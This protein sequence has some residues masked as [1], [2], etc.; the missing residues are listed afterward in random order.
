M[1]SSRTVKD[2]RDEEFDTIIDVRSPD[3]FADDH[4]PGAINLPVLSNEERVEVGTLY[5]Q[6]SP[7]RARVVGAALV[8]RN[9]GVHIADSLAE[10][11]GGWKPLIYCWRGGQRSQSMTE[12]LSQIGW[13]VCRLEGGYKT[14]RN[15]VMSELKSQL[16]SFSP[17]IVQGATGTGK[18]RLLQA[19]REAGEQVLD[20]EGLAEHRGSVLGGIPGRNQPSQRL[21]ESRIWSALK[22]LD[23]ERPVLV[24]AESSKVGEVHVPTELWKKMK[25]A[26]RVEITLS[27]EERVAL[28]L[29]EYA[30]WTQTPD[31]LIAKLK[32]LRYRLG[33]ELVQSW[34]D[35]IEAKDWSVFVKALLEAHYDRAY[36]TAS[37][38]REGKRWPPILVPARD[39]HAHADVLTPLR[40]VL[41]ELSN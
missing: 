2:W 38:R 6:V 9:I 12:V 8:S 21:F 7:F 18:T 40:A 33:N 13:R 34:I 26:P 32:P 30:H 10:K 5:S 41:Q 28:L 25:V 39:K 35:L 19:C 23:L 20:L 17:L 16:A 1:T 3:E 4:I 31:A 29:E 37:N 22:A 11:P 14:Y 24:E 36:T 15:K 27:M